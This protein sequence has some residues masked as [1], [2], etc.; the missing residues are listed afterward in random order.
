MPR[1]IDVKKGIYEESV[2]QLRKT[3]KNKGKGGMKKVTQKSKKIK[4]SMIEQLRKRGA[5]IPVYLEL[6]DKYIGLTEQMIDM[7]KNIK[8]KG[9]TYEA[10]SAAG[11]V[12]EKDNPD[13]KNILAYHDKRLAILKQLDM[14]PETVIPEV[15]EEDDL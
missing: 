8:K 9:R 6:V 2:R 10:I 5:D 11:K 12:Y 4:E 1:I 15:T 13:V 3:A 14:T 7:E